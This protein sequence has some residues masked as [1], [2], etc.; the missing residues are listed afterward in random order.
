M[1]DCVL[2]YATET[3]V[4]LER[5]I[6]Y[7]KV[8]QGIRLSIIIPFYNVEQ[9]IAQC[10]DSVYKQD[11][12]EEEYEVICVNDYSPDN[13]R[14]IVKEYQKKHKNLI[15]IEHERNKK[16]G[17]ARNTGLKTAHGKYVLFLDSDD[18]LKEKSIGR[19]LKE[20]EDGCDYIHFGNWIW[21]GKA[22]K[23]VP[24]YGELP[25]NTGTDLFVGGIVPWS[26][27]IVAWN[28]IY[29]LDFI[30]EN[31]LY[32]VE[33]LM[34]EDNDYAFRVSLAATR[35]RHIDF[36]PYVYRDNPYSITGQTI[37]V[38]RLLYWQKIWPYVLELEP[39]L[40]QKDK[41]YK[42][43]IQA[44]IRTDLEEIVRHM[45]YLDASDKK[46]VKEA[47][48]IGNWLKVISYLPL[49]RRIRYIYELLRA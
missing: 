43:I 5:K 29:R 49:K 41:R 15:L 31:N 39:K 7:Q 8:M 24:K 17:G 18:F 33:D 27:Q 35:C 36:A 21:Y 44:Y 26:A 13:S 6:I 12:P 11:I 34:Y 9:Y 45:Q 46:K 37:N 19:L 14:E 3:H 25:I 48:S 23:E 1:A 32:F 28:K 30:R 38:Q 2:V 40:E 22:Y 47:L 10:L 42:S 4:H 16:L 20:I